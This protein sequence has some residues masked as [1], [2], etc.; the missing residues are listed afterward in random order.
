MLNRILL[1]LFIIASIIFLYSCKTPAPTGKKTYTV[2]RV[3]VKNGVSIVRFKEIGGVWLIPTDT[4]K[5]HSTIE[6]NFVHSN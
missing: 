3:K 6:I 1:W 4:L 2:R 5:K